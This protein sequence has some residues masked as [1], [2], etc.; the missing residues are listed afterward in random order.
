MILVDE[1]ASVERSVDRPCRLDLCI[2]CISKDVVV[3]KFCERGMFIQFSVGEEDASV[4]EHINVVRIVRLQ[5]AFDLGRAYVLTQPAKD[6]G[7][8]NP[9]TYLLACTVGDPTTVQKKFFMKRGTCPYCKRDGISFNADGTMR[10]HMH[11]PGPPSAS[12][13]ASLA[14][15]R[16]PSSSQSGTSFSSM[17]T[18]SSAIHDERREMEKT[19]LENDKYLKAQADKFKEQESKR[20][21]E[22]KAAAE[23]QAAEKEVA[24]EEAAR[25]AIPYNEE[26]VRRQYVPC[27]GQ[28]EHY[29]GTNVHAYYLNR[30]YSIINI[31]DP[32][33]V[34]KPQPKPTK[35][36][37]WQWRMVR[38]DSPFGDTSQ[39]CEGEEELQW[40]YT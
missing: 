39:L 14:L 29:R 24:E 27:S 20:K 19:R 33:R 12:Q 6:H 36:R 23:K 21:E 8:R 31:N 7:M 25:A 40:V 1:P 35:K 34:P 17:F 37:K 4:G 38:Y 16:I 18:S 13:A 10:K 26:S 9:K 28:V 30:D 5:Q 15:P 32:P 22:E 11:C 2:G 3:Q